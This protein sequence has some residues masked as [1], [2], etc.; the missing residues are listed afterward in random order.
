[1]KPIAAGFLPW[2]RCCCRRPPRR[3]A[4]S[5][6]GSPLARRADALERA[7][8]EI[9]Y[10]ATAGNDRF[11]T[12]V[13]QQR[14]GVLID[15]YR[16][17]QSGVATGP[18]PGLGAHQRSRLLHPRSAE[19][20]RQEPRRDLRLR[21]VPGRRDLLPSWGRP[22]TAIPP[23]TS[24]TRPGAD[25]QARRRRTSAGRVRP[26]LRHVDR[27]PRLP[28]VPESALR[29]RQMARAQRRQARDLGGLR[30]AS[31]PTAT[32]ARDSE[33]GSAISLDGSIE[34]PFRVGMAC[35]GCHIAFDPLKPP[36]DPAHP[37]VGEHRGAVGNQYAAHLG[38]DGLGHAARTASSGRSFT[39][40]RPGTVDTSAMPN[41]QVT[42]PRH[43]E[44]DHQYRPAALFTRRD[45]VAQGGGCPAG[46]GASDD[47]LVRARQA[48]QVLGAAHA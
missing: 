39:R 23:A 47:V 16:I 46:A 6:R 19:L 36:K 41:D 35:G 28:Q 33:C 11:H 2:A 18:V 3:K 9:W 38:D 24:R 22:A 31:S 5:A 40:A 4:S 8:R 13:F 14:L 20:P 26:G 15:W 29:R 37:D 27:C 1:M 44:R 25:R 48:R 42:Q 34:P 17:L 45:Q 30:R 21:L 10:K 12:Y 32:S 43:D 7:G